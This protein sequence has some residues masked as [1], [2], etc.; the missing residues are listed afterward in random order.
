MVRQWR[1][2]ASYHG[3]NKKKGVNS[4]QAVEK[5]KYNLICHAELVSASNKFNVL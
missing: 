4:L 1:A 5:L 3:K 2:N